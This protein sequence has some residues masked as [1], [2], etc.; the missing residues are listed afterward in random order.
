MVEAYASSLGPPGDNLR[1]AG[2]TVP[3]GSAT[4]PK[5]YSAT[6]TV[7]ANTLQEHVPGGNSGAYRLSISAFLD[8]TLPSPGY[9]IVGFA[10]GPTIKAEVPA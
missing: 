7:L 5:T 10:D 4:D 3:V 2:L 9:D 8:S 1:I 6:L